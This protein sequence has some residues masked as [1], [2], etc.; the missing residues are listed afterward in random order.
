MIGWLELVS[1]SSIACLLATPALLLLGCWLEP[2][3]PS[4]WEGFIPRIYEHEVARVF[5]TAEYACVA[6]T[7]ALF[8]SATVSLFYLKDERRFKIGMVF[9]CL[10]LLTLLALYPAAVLPPTK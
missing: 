8:L 4:R 1:K 9:V 10:G 3:N 7:I 2:A 6:A 5:L